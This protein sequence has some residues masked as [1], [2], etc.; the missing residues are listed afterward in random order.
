M[1]SKDC[2][3]LAKERDQCSVAFSTNSHENHQHG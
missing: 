2:K 3:R 1:I